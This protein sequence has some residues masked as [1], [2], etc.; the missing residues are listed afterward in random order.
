M[1]NAQAVKIFKNRKKSEAELKIAKEAFRK[2]DRKLV[3]AEKEF[4]ESREITEVFEGKALVVLLFHDGAGIS[5]PW[6]KRS[7][8]L[9]RNA[10]DRRRWGLRTY[11]KGKETWYGKDWKT[12]KEAVEATKRWVAFGLKPWFNGDAG[13]DCHAVVRDALDKTEVPDE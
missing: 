2:A 3:K 4:K 13:G 8:E 7:A 9:Y 5:A 6:T 1:T 12:R 10:T 11:N